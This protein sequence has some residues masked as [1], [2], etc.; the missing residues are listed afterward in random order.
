MKCIWKMRDDDF[1][2]CP[3][4]GCT[5]ISFDGKHMLCPSCGAREIKRLRRQVARLTKDAADRRWAGRALKNLEDAII[6]KIV[7]G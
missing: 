7:G 4:C 5:L 3:I 6:K 1:G 2:E